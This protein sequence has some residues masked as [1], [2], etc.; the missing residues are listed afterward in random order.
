MLHT[1]AWLNS[2]VLILRSF[3][4][5]VLTNYVLMETNAKPQAARLG[6]R[7]LIRLCNEK[8]ICAARDLAEFTKNGINASFIV[9]L[10]HKC[11]HFEDSLDEPVIGQGPQRSSQTE[12]EIQEAVHQICELG[13]KIWANEP[14]RYREYTFSLAPRAMMSGRI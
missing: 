6:S 1:V 2:L 10:A 8:L 4:F 5:Q 14:A 3:H 9:A 7:E 11:E 12:Q 13:Q